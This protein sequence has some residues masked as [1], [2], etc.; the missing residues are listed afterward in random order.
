MTDQH[1]YSNNVGTP[2]LILRSDDLGNGIVLNQ[3]Y[4]ELEIPEPV[5]E[6]GVRVVLDTHKLLALIDA[7]A[8]ESMRGYLRERSD[9]MDS[10]D[11]SCSTLED[12]LP[13][14][15]AAEAARYRIDAAPEADSPE[16]IDERVPPREALL[17]DAQER[18]LYLIEQ[19]TKTLPADEAPALAHWIITGG[20]DVL[21]DLTLSGED[22]N[23]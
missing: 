20:M 7:A 3:G 10:P 12:M 2:L 8:P 4:I 22:L 16:D 17:T 5:A 13:A 15:L 21:E 9:L 14:D 11:E 1:I 6:H 23:R 18:R 19:L